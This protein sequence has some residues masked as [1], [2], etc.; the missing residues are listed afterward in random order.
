MPGRGRYHWCRNLAQRLLVMVMIVVVVIWVVLAV[1][2][3]VTP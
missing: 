1:D 2:R 3:T